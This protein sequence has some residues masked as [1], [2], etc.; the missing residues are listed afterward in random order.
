MNYQG[1][2]GPI[3][4]LDQAD[5]ILQQL[6]AGTPTI[7]CAKSKCECGLCAPKAK[8]PDTYQTIMRKYAIPNPDVL[9]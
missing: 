1:E 2:V 4:T 6:R 5:K 8:N 9:H 3:G 7:Q